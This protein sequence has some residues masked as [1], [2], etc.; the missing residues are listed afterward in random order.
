MF[1][2]KYQF[3]GGHRY[4]TRN[5]FVDRNFINIWNEYVPEPFKSDTERAFKLR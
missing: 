1:S 3:V 4:G 2:K 5:T